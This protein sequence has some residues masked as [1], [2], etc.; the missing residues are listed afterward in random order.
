MRHSLAALLAPA[1]LLPVLVAS[2]AAAATGGLTASDAL[3]QLVTATPVS[4][5]Y[6]RS[7]FQHWI[8]ADGNGCD[9]RQEVLIAESTT[10]VVKGAGCTVVSGTWYSWYDGQTWT[11]PSD[12]DIDHLVQIGRASCRERV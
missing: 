11:D 4:V 7:L 2:P 3:A 10:P 5:G 6:D 9:T 12:V 8:D 1:L